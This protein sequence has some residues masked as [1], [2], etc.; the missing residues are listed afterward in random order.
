MRNK[1]LLPACGAIVKLIYVP[2]LCF[3]QLM[4]NNNVAITINGG[5]LTVNGDIL[6]NPGTTINNSGLVQLTGNWINNSGNNC[7]GT[8]A[9]T[10][11]LIGANQTIGGTNSTVFNN[12]ST[13]GSGTKTLLVNTTVGG[14]NATPSG[15]LICYSSVLDLNGKTVFITNPSPSG[16]GLVAGSILSE[17]PDNSSKVDW[18]MQNFTGSH[19]IP[20]SNANGTPILFT[21]DLVSGTHGHVVISTYAT[22]S[23]NVPYPVAPNSVTSLSTLGDGTPSKM[24]HRFWEVDVENPGVQSALLLRF[25]TVTEAAAGSGYLNA[26]RW[27]NTSSW[28]YPSAGQLQLSSNTLLVVNNFKYGT[29]GVAKGASPLPMTLISFDAKMNSSKQ[30]DVSWVTASEINNDYFTVQR[31]SDAYTFESIA[32]VDGA[33]NST[34]TLNYYYMDKNPMRGVSYY[35]LKQTDYDGT[36]SYSEIAAVNNAGMGANDVTIFPNPVKDYALISVRSTI[37]D[38]GEIVFELYDMTGKLVM[39]KKLSE[40][41]SLGENIFRFEKENLLPG[42]YFYRTTLDA[43]TSGEGRMVIQ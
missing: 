13:M 15:S 6:N 1:I 7:F 3:G 29:F 22:N 41:N 38:S 25:D 32:T 35:R 4:T 20:F 9:G 16:I 14:G 18:N 19:F 11:Y 8:S 42:A 23:L 24:V 34:A 39:R 2:V 17:R 37:K 36:T 28:E 31:S 12:L 5:Q 10:V 27:D 26:Q 43:E 40:M 33:G 30:V 21:Y